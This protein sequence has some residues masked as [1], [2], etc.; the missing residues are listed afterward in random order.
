MKISKKIGIY[1]LFTLFIMLIVSNLAYAG[2]SST[3]HNLS[4]SGSGDIKSSTEDKICVFC[5]T[6]HNSNP[7]TALWNH[8][9]QANTYTMY[10]D[11]VSKT[12]DATVSSAPDGASK[13]C[14]S[15]H[16]GTIAI[17]SLN[18]R[19]ISAGDSGSGKL[20]AS[21]HFADATNVNLGTDLTNDHPI[22]LVYDSTLASGDSG[23]GNL[24]DPSVSSGLGGTIQSDMLDGSSK[25][26]CTSC[27]DP[28]DNSKG[29]FLLMKNDDGTYGGTLC[30]VCHE[31]GDKAINATWANSIHRNSTGYDYTMDSTTKS[32]A[33]WGCD[34]CHVNHNVPTGNVRL[35]R[36]VEE[37]DCYKC[38]SSTSSISPS[39]PGIEDE[40]N[41]S[42]THPVENQSGVHYPGEPYDADAS[43]QPARHVECTD[44]HDPHAAQTEANHKAAPNLPASLMGIDGLGVSFT[45]FWGNLSFTRKQDIDEE[46]ELCL[47]CHSSYNYGSSP[48]TSP[49]RQ[50]LEGADAT[51]QT[52]IAKQFNTNNI[53][54]HSVMGKRYDTAPADRGN[55]T[56]FVGT[57]RSGNAWSWTS[58]LLCTDCHG[59]DDATDPVQG[60]HGSGYYFILKAPWARDSGPE[61]EAGTG[62]S[63]T[64]D[65]LCFNCH[66]W[67]VYASQSAYANDTSVTGFSGNG[68]NLHAIHGSKRGC[69][70]C[71]SV[72]PHGYDNPKYPD[73]AN[74]PYNLEPK[75]MLVEM[76]EPSPYSDGSYLEV[77]NWRKSGNWQENDCSAHNSGSQYVKFGAPGCG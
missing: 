32:V 30:L 33:L 22:S 25:M 8:N 63:G 70:T 47:K 12:M 68:Q 19:T 40:F 56:S 51:P 14:L 7:S 76:D 65:H 48:P 66:N 77:V 37:A 21:E 4:T 73:G 46:Y 28:H 9:T 42:W 72:V 23:I 45:G 18:E 49:S 29:N 2:I 67:D 50:N 16:D 34:A 31:R 60:P 61:G 69:N 26:Q 10:D 43:N 36:N 13:L 64:S 15:C 57:D 20:D 35:K 3:V 1:L 5:H 62:T 58:R 39:V 11:T 55:S 6:P 44:C 24:K 52:P 38:H 17:G 74:D 27:H 54:Y 53:S 71:H 41:K 59:N 75:A